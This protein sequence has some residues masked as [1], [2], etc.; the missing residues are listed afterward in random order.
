[1]LQFIMK[2]LTDADPELPNRYKEENKVWGTKATD[3]DS[4]KQSYQ[5]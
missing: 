5:S 3:L 4:L 1:M 2:K